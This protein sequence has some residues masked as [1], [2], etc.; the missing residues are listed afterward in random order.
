[1][2]LETYNTGQAHTDDK[3][4]TSHKSVETKAVDIKG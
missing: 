1:M 4:H 2:S 3:I